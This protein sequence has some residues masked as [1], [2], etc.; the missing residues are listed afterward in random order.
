MGNFPL[1]TST[2]PLLKRVDF[3]RNNHIREGFKKGLYLG[4]GMLK[5]QFNALLHEELSLFYFQY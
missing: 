4:S 1:L 5:K 2:P 3:K